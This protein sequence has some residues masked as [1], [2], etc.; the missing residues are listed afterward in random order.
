[1]SEVPSSLGPLFPIKPPVDSLQ[2][3]DRR[4]QNRPFLRDL[5]PVAPL[6]HLRAEEVKS[7]STWPSSLVVHS[8]G[9]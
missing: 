3:R 7:G 4:P 8:T 1:M 9:M 2:S 6:P 5:V